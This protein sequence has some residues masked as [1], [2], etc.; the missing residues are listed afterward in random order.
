MT[1]WKWNEVVYKQKNISPEGAEYLKKERKHFIR[2]VLSDLKRW[3]NEFLDNTYCDRIDR[4]RT[5]D[6]MI[7]WKLQKDKENKL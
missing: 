5:F 1:K 7:L 4:H 6:K 2:D 3:I